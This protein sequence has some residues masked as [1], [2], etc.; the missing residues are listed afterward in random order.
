MGGHTPRGF[1]G[2]GGGIF[3]GDNLNSRFPNG[4]GVQA[5]IS[6][7][8]SQH[9]GRDMQTAVLSTNFL[10]VHGT[11]FKDLGAIIFEWVQ[12]SKFSSTLW[13]IPADAAAGCS[14]IV[15]LPDRYAECDLTKPVQ[16][17]LAEKATFLQFRL[18][19]EAASDS[20]GQQDLAL[21]NRG[22]VNV[23]EGGVLA[24]TLR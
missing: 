17:A 21:F 16:D 1:R 20:D 3:V 13:N 2:Q 24:L 8:I 10:N 11:P 9:H 22:L 15:A 5:F 7:D 12:F 4:D 23:N 19:F 14:L 6:F 18:R